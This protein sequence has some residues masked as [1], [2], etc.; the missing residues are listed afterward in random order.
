MYGSGKISIAENSYIGRFSLLQSAEGYEISVG[1][2]CSIGPFFSAWT[3]SSDVDSDFNFKDSIKP[4]IGN[5]IIK[6]A[7]WIGVNVLVS[8]GVTIGS[9]A[10][11]GANSVVTK[12]IPDNAIAAGI[13]AKII[14]YKNL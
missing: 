13:P 6:D 3:H 5:I 10:I 8:P 9:N 7:V 2:N 1:K 4:K 14:R 12:D 11:V